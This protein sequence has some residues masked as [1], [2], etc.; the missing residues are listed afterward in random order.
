MLAEQAAAEESNTETRL[1]VRCHRFLRPLWRVWETN[2]VASFRR[3][4]HGES[5]LE[6]E[7]SSSLASSTGSWKSL[8]GGEPVISVGALIVEDESCITSPELDIELLQAV[9]TE[10]TSRASPK[11]H[12]LS[13][14]HLS[15]VCGTESW[16]Y[17]QPNEGNWIA[18]NKQLKTVIMNGFFPSLKTEYILIFLTFETKTLSLI[19][20]YSVHQNQIKDFS[21]LHVDWDIFWLIKLELRCYGGNRITIFIFNNCK[22]PK[23][24][25]RNLPKISTVV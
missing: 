19:S 16:V 18:Y 1:A 11:L 24:K 4:Y 22:E 17:N 8:Y 7:L 9:A 12:E 25:G 23:K 21:N 3:W 20:D 2:V 15:D 5:M 13:S 10:S 14:L 6:A